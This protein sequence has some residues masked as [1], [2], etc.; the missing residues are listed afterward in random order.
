M[1]STAGRVVNGCRVVYDSISHGR[2]LSVIPVPE[3][4][5][6]VP[7]PSPLSILEARNKLYSLFARLVKCLVEDGL[8]IGV[9]D[10]GYEFGLQIRDVEL[11]SYI[12][13]KV[14]LEKP[15]LRLKT[16]PVR[17]DS[18]FN[19]VLVESNCSA[20]IPLRTSAPLPSLGAALVSFS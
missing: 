15:I 3:R 7:V 18:S 20:I 4:V 12:C 1:T 9:V 2:T 13:A 5:G 16:V 8:S 17:R 10:V 6:E 14:G 19:V 11:N